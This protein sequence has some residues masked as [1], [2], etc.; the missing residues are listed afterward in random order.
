MLCLKY[1]NQLR[2]I[3]C[4]INY[5]LYGLIMCVSQYLYCSQVDAFI[6]S[7]VDVVDSGP[8]SLKKAQRAAT[9]V[10]VHTCWVVGVGFLIGAS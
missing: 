6:L 2:L 4:I 1:C 8:A 9:R 7:H 3:D 5:K 10:H